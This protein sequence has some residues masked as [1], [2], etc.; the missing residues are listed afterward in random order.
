MRYRD[1]LDETTQEKKWRVDGESRWKKLKV[2]GVTESWKE[3][4]REE[5]A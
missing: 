4:E 2:D 3:E 1:I 5:G